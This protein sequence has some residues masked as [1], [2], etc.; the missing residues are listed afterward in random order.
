MGRRLNQWEW[1]ES[2]IRSKVTVGDSMNVKL[3]LKGRSFML[4]A[5]KGLYDPMESYKCMH[6]TSHHC[7]ISSGYFVPLFGRRVF[8]TDVGISNAQSANHWK[9][10]LPTHHD[11]LILV[12]FLSHWSWIYLA[13]HLASSSGHFLTFH[14]WLSMCYT[15]SVAGHWSELGVILKKLLLSLSVEWHEKWW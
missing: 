14:G 5:M 12:E 6:I 15:Q 2:K 11:C 7:M 3:L 9:S 4:R 8:S 10:Q 1:L 13:K